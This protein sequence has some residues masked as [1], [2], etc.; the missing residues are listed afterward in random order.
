MRPLNTAS[1]RQTKIGS[2]ISDRK[3]S[4]FAHHLWDDDDVF[5]ELNMASLVQNSALFDHSVFKPNFRATVCGQGSHRGQ[6]WNAYC[7]AMAEQRLA[8]S[9]GKYA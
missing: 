8:K 2:V 4:G 9:M 3:K 5:N 1:H 7:F 6:L